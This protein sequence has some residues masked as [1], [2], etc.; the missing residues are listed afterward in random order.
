[1]VGFLLKQSDTIKLLII[2][3]ISSL[4]LSLFNIEVDNPYYPITYQKK[5]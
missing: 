5:K 4:S 1:M 2:W 3:D